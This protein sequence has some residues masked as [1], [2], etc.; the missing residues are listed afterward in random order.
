MRLENFGELPYSERVRTF[1][2]WTVSD[3]R[4]IS[5][6]AGRGRIVRRFS[7]HGTAMLDLGC[8][9]TFTNRKW[10]V[11]EARI[12]SWQDI[13]GNTHYGSASEQKGVNRILRGAGIT[14]HCYRRNGGNPRYEVVS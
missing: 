5:S 8:A 13:A 2:N 3:F 1:G 9:D 14:T 6:V 11:V 10:S 12:G 4:I 7:Y